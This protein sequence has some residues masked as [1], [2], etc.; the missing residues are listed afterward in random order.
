VRDIILGIIGA[1]VGGAIFTALGFAGVTGVNLSSI[2]VAV[3]G[4]VIVLVLY[5]TLIHQRA[6]A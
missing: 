3:I 1:I 4:A 5:H 2:I 6:S